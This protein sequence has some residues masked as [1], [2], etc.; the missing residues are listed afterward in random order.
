MDA[1]DFFW[2]KTL[3]RKQIL[4]KDILS[5]LEEIIMFFSSQ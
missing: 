1:Q 5:R 2:D 3:E 4:E